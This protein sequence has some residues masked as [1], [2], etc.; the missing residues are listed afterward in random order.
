MDF[1]FDFGWVFFAILL[2]LS[3]FHSVSSR[4]DIC[5]VAH[6]KDVKN[7]WQKLFLS[8]LIPATQFPSPKVSDIDHFCG[9][10]SNILCID[11]YTN[12]IFIGFYPN[13]STSNI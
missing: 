4:K 6:L 11:K 12:I 2:D 10:F 13:E 8:P 7:T 1:G 3:N 9:P 5:M